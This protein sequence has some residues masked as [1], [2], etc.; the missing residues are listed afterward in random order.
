MACGM[1]ASAITVDNLAFFAFWLRATEIKFGRSFFSNRTILNTSLFFLS[2]TL[3]D[4]H[5][6]IYCP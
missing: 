5:L 2:S 3:N 4:S 1:R 6:I